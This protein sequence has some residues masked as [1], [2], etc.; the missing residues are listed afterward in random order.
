[1]RRIERLDNQIRNCPRFDFVAGKMHPMRRIVRRETFEH[2][3]D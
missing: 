1:L 3:R 2:E